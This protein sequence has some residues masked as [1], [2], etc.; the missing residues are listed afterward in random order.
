MLWENCILDFNRSVA[1]KNVQQ[2][3]LLTQNLH[4]IKPV[5]ITAQVGKILRRLHP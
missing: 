5:K 1:L 2:L 3:E 4:K